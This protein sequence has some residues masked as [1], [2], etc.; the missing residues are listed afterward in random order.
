MSNGDWKQVTAIDVG[1]RNFAWCTLDTAHLTEPL[2]WHVE[3]LWEARP[4][5]R[6]TPTKED[7]MQIATE[8][9]DRNEPILRSSDLVVL[10]NQIRTPCIVLNAAIFSRCYGRA[11]VVHPMT[12]G[13]YWKLP[14]TRDAKKA[15]GIVIAQQITRNA[16]PRVYK[17]DDLAD[18]FLMAAWGMM[19]VGGATHHD[20]L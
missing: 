13:A 20:F 5:R 8:W 3:D 12:V 17:R 18:T 15:K 1:W 16:F 19:Q 10:E 6:K 7:L 14:T 11:R 9:C 2:H 4:S